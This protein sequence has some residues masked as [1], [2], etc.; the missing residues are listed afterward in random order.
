[1]LAT[2]V[3]VASAQGVVQDES[4]LA[5]V[6][7][8]LAYDCLFPWTV[9]G[10]E[11]WLRCL[12]EEL[13]AEGNEVTYLTRLQWDPCSPPDLL[14]VNVV[15]VS[16]ADELYGADGTRRTG[17]AIRYG[18]GVFHH[19]L[20]NRDS[21]DVVHVTVAPFFGLLG[22]RAALIGTRI[23][24]FAD[25]DEAWTGG[26][27]HSYA[28]PVR[29]RIGRFLQ[30]LC[31][32][33]T[34]NAF[35]KSRL[36][37]RRLRS[38][39]FIGELTVLPGLYD[40]PSSLGAGEAA[41]PPL[42]V[43]AGRHIPEKRVLAIPAA[44]A[45]ARRAIP[46]LTCRILGDG[47]ESDSLAREISRL[48]A[49]GFIEA[50]GFVD[51]ETVMGS[52]AQATCLILPSSREGYGIVVAE[53]AARGTPTVL[54]AGEDNAAVELVEEG[55]N[56]FVAPTSSPDD[57]AAA[58]VCAVRGGQELRESTFAWFEARSDSISA[59][60]SALVVADRHQ[61]GFG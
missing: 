30:W 40:G 16:P 39:G 26:Y 36:H 38:L 32:H 15:A 19:L 35:V 45:A 8:C 25:W 41:D 58:I 47:P 13:A 23:P 9:G 53:A 57:L 1:M 48:N 61:T 44:I 59:R 18:L 55:T 34:R 28:G 49:E 12:A 54:V 7:V 56:G 31:V 24:L 3:E 33:S 37:E 43:F 4:R 46:D 2:T 6:R 14:G 20:R 51:F 50:P 10:A 27:W 42:V 17:E 11:R 60:K 29:G 21:Y 5:P 22:A 52:I